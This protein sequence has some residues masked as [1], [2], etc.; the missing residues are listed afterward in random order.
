MIQ[1]IREPIALIDSSGINLRRNPW[2]GRSSV[3]ES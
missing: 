2:Y 1:T 3:S